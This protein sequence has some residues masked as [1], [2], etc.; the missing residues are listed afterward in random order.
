MQ[1][2]I[3]EGKDLIATQIKAAITL[4]GKIIVTGSGMVFLSEICACVCI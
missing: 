1:G 4:D 3:E 2:Q